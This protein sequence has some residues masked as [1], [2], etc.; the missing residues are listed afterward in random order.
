[1]T[2]SVP[3]TRTYR[4]IKKTKGPKSSSLFDLDASMV[5][6]SADIESQMSHRID[7]EEASIAKEENEEE[8]REMKSL[9]NQSSVHDAEDDDAM[10]SIS[11]RTD[12]SK[13][14]VG[15]KSLKSAHTKSTH[16]SRP[17][18]HVGSVYSKQS[19]SH[20]VEWTKMSHE[21]ARLKNRNDEL[22]R[23]VAY[24]KWVVQNE[25]EEKE[26][27]EA[28]RQLRRERRALRKGNVHTHKLPNLD[29]HSD[30]DQKAKENRASNASSHVILIFRFKEACLMHGIRRDKKF[31]WRSNGKLR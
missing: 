23:Q 28:Q 11:K 31:L 21:N 29:E 20:S 18:T 2:W 9:P 15:A 27:Q 12:V 7:P 14:S 4:D 10:T 13:T 22:E 8:S 3:A 30:E 25:R 1:M 19:S 17:P 5:S 6:I 24:W 16:P 26:K